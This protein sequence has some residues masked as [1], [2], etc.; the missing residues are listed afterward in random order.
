[1]RLAEMLSYSDIQSLTRI[2]NHYGCDSSSNSKNTLIQAILNAVNKRETVERTLRELSPAD[3]RFLNSFLFEPSGSFTLEDLIARVLQVQSSS[4]PPQPDELNKQTRVKP[5][6]LVTEYIKRGWLFNGVHANTK[7]LFQF[8][9]DLKQK[10]SQML[11]KQFEQQLQY[12]AEPAVYREEHLLILEDISLFMQF[13][14]AEVIPLTAD[15]VLHKRQLQQALNQLH[16]EEELPEKAAWRFGYGRKFKFYPQR[17]SFLYDYCYFN[18]YISEAKDRLTLTD[19]GKEKIQNGIQEELIEVYRFWLRLYKTPIYNI[20]T[21]VH[22]IDKLA[23]RWVSVKSLTAVLAPFIKRYYYDRA[24]DVLVKRILLMMHH[25]GLIRISG[26]ES[27]ALLHP[28]VLI[29]MSPRGSP[30]IRGTYV[31]D[32]EAIEYALL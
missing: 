21:L 22:W 6:Q 13:V 4:M 8:P 30:V 24:E 16:I 20:N 5:R 9:Q 32:R 31:T 15:G 12:N 18:G 17:F 27:I 3:L 28:D 1:M 10:F 14:D 25:L 11:Q 29:Q 23:Q 19:T 7:Y 2:A 26:T